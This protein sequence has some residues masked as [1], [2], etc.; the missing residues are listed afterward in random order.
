MDRHTHPSA[1]ARMRAQNRRSVLA[2]ILVA[3]LVVGLGGYSLALWRPATFSPAKV[4]MFI[5]QR[6]AGS[7]CSGFPQAPHPPMI[8]SAPPDTRARAHGARLPAAL[9]ISAPDIPI[10]LPVFDS[11]S[12]TDDPLKDWN[13]QP[14]ADPAPPQS[15][16]PIKARSRWFR[17]AGD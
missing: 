17:G 15:K 10:A 16:W 5:L 13:F 7:G 9:I 6:P 12:A 3:M 14:A 4:E 1:R 11:G 2:T 8:P